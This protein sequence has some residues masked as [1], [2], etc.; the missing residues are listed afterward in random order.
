MTFEIV[1]DKE[2]RSLMEIVND[3]MD[4]R[5]FK[6]KNLIT[7][8]IDTAEHR[9]IICPFGD[10]HYG[11]ENF[12][13]ELFM[14]NLNWAWENK[15]VYI[16][17][18]GDWLEAATR[19]SVGSGVY[20]Q[21]ENAGGQ[22]DEVVR[23]FKPFADEGRILGIT[24]GNHEDRIYNATGVD[25]TRIMAS[26]L[27]VSY[28][29]NGG[30]FRIRVGPKSGPHAKNA[31]IYH[32]YATHGSSGATLPHT[33]IKRCLDLATFI[34]ADVYLM[35]HV[36]DEQVLT[37]EYHCIDNRNRAILKSNKYFVLTGHYLNWTDSYAQM[38]SM[39]PSKQGTP[40]IKL[41]SDKHLVRISL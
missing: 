8:D 10:M 5:R 23:L 26:M 38:K 9:P 1:D 37:Q 16:I 39:R 31:Q 27:G 17:G 3:E 12:N 30:F 32:I 2:G 6:A 35:G 21:K 41:G 20:D 25:A 28:F 11:S 33:K 4:K 18:M 36:H 19:N 22:L 40:K 15:N 24:N 7:V 13:R 34:D 29:K 14:E